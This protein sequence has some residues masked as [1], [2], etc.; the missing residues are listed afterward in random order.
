MSATHKTPL[1]KTICLTFDVEDYFQVENLRSIYPLDTWDRQ[2]FRVE[3]PTIQILDLLDQHHIKG[4]FFVLGWVAERLPYLVKEIHAQGHEIASHG[5]SHKLNTPEFFSDS[6]LSDD[7]KRSKDLLENIIGE[8]VLGYRAPSFS[9]HEKVL[10][11]LKDLDFHYDSSFNPIS[12]N[13]RC[14]QINTNSNTNSFLHKTGVQE[15]SIPQQLLFGRKI[16]L[17]GGGYFRLYPLTFFLK[18]VQKYLQ[19]NDLMIFY[20]HPWELDSK[21]PRFWTELRIDHGFRHYYGLK[22]SASKLEKF[23]QWGK[24]KQVNF[25]RIDQY[26]KTA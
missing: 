20:L 11:I 2:I 7:I 16:P 1:G 13:K 24:K 18:L 8:K 26:L 14:G 19:D 23:I 4:T 15:F 12:W 6:E 5:Y 9:I 17:G 21:Q 22:S 3:R 10:S 25:S